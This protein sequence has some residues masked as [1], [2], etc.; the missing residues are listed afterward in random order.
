MP[1]NKKGPSSWRL[2]EKEKWLVYDY[3]FP[4]KKTLTHE[5]SN[6]SGC[7]RVLHALSVK[8]TTDLLLRALETRAVH[9]SMPFLDV[10]GN[11]EMIITLS[12]LSRMHWIA[13]MSWQTEIKKATKCRTFYDQLSISL[14]PVLF[15]SW[16][17]RVVSCKS[18]TS[19]TAP[20]NLCESSLFPCTRW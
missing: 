20:E 1:W 13:S 8:R 11:C 5:A 9:L 17:I 2:Y 18:C 15:N 12:T 4:N 6:F 19:L 3:L 14:L 7:Q 16:K 10:S